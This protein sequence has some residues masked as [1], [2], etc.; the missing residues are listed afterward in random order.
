MELRLV[1]HPVQQRIL[2]ISR[3]NNADY[4][5]A[6]FRP[7]AVLQLRLSHCIMSTDLIIPS[8]PRRLGDGRTVV[9]GFKGTGHRV[10]RT[11]RQLASVVDTL[12]YDLLRTRMERFS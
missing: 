2:R 9:I 7:S 1:S 12:Q 11:A 6:P 8:P 4:G 5:C 10:L 3:V